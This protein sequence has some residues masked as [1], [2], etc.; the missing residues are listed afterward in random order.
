MS[1]HEVTRPGV[2]QQGH[3]LGDSPRR[4]YQGLVGDG[5]RIGRVGRTWG[6][7]W[8]MGH[9]LIFRVPAIS[10]IGHIFPGTLKDWQELV[11]GLI[12]GFRQVSLAPDPG[13]VH[14]P[15]HRWLIE[16]RR[17]HRIT[18]QLERPTEGLCG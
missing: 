7:W 11:Q 9:G 2:T 1:E 17:Q 3:L 6:R 4:A 8:C 15:I 14:S 16:S 10:H 13:I 12:V 5:A 18:I